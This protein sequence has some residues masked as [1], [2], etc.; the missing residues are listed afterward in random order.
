MMEDVREE[1]Q[2]RRTQKKKKRRQGWITFG[3]IV[4]LLLYGGYQLYQGVFATI[5]TEQAASYRRLG[6]FYH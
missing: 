1:R 3:V 2:R 5:Q 6:V 4:L